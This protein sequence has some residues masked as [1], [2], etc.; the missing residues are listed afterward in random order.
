VSRFERFALDSPA[1]TGGEYVVRSP[2]VVSGWV[3]AHDG[4]A[5]T[6]VQVEVDG[7]VR[8]HAATGLRRFDVHDVFPGEPEALW[9]GFAAEVF[10]DDLERSTVTVAVSATVEDREFPL[11]RFPAR[12]DGL[13][14]VVP[15]RPRAWRFVDV[16]GCPL[17]RGDLDEVES[18]WRCRGCG[19]RFPARRGVPVF[20]RGG[21]VIQSR[22]LEVHPTN[23]NA[24]DQT[25]II[26]DPANALVL[27]LG[28]GNPRL[29]EHHPNVVFHEWAHY[30]HTDVVSVCDRLP[31]REGVFDAVISKATFEHVA[32]PWEMA[33][34]VYRVLKPGGLVHVDTAF[35]QPLH[36]DPHHFFNMTQ[37]GVREI[38]RR[39]Q[40]VRCGVKPYQTPAHGLRMQI[41]VL[42]DHLHAAEWRRRFEALRE[43]L[44]DLDSALDAKGRERLAAGVFFEGTKPAA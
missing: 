17:C 14:R 32:R 2:F 30:A 5:V 43:S 35:M 28:A 24:E 42:L 27:D 11:A 33:D 31:Y 9:S 36:A 10:A 13:D 7:R 4:R 18:C 37:N 25:A 15:P 19:T 8:A 44:G 6:S 16:L 21:E 26:M 40:L 39:F 1:P 34:E 3:L 23:P 29:S 38:F 12:V 41:E 22:L 20:T